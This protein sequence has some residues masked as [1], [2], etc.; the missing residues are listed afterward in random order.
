MSGTGTPDESLAPVL[1]A[2]ATLYSPSDRQAKEQAN[3]YLEQFQQN[4]CTQRI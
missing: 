2:L 1:S 3:A 4:V